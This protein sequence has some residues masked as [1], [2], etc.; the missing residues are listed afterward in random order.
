[1]LILA[2]MDDI[3]QKIIL[4]LE[5]DSRVS[6]SKIAKRTGIPQTTVHYRIKKLVE[7]KVIERYTV[8]L[9]PE[10]IGKSILAYVLVLYDTQAMKDSNYRYEETA[11]GIKAIPGVEEFAYTTGQYDIILK[12]TAGSVKELS[13]VV[14][15]RLR[16]IP[17]VLRTETLVVMNYFRK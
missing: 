13:S 1:M 8:I 11:N 4:E 17:G 2:T 5:K 7:E 14:L 12:V 3:D 10:K 9:N 15:E 6:T 16:K